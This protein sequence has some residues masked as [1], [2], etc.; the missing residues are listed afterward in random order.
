M[1]LQRKSIQPGIFVL[2]MAGTIHMGPECERINREIDEHIG[3]NETRLVFDLT[4]VTHIDS[5]MIGVL[6][7]SHSRLKKAGGAL[8]L[9]VTKGMVEYVLKMTSVN[10]VIPLYPTAHEACADFHPAKTQP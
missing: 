6:V 2:E 7:K 10:K 8:R 1:E 5:A 4:N 9:V 3:R